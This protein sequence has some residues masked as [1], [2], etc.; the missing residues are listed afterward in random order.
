MPAISI[1]WLIQLRLQGEIID[2]TAP[3]ELYVFDSYI[4]KTVLSFLAFFPDA[5]RIG[6]GVHPGA[7]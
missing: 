5:S 6:T 4:S 1:A 2:K 7:W 3:G